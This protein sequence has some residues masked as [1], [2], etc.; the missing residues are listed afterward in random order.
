MKYN[1]GQKFKV[2]IRTGF[3]LD[4]CVE[5]EITKICGDI[6]WIRYKTNDGA[7]KKLFGYEKNLDKIIIPE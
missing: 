4:T 5:R 3:H 2:L 7:Y 6:I 1:V